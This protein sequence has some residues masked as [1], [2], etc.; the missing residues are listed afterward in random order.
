MGI[1]QRLDDLKGSSGSDYIWCSWFYHRITQE[2]HVRRPQDGGMILQPTW[3]VERRE[4]KIP[5]RRQCV[6]QETISCLLK[7]L[8]IAGKIHLWAMEKGFGYLLTSAFGSSCSWT[9]ADVG[10]GENKL[11]NSYRTDVGLQRA[12]VTHRCSLLPVSGRAMRA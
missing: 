9:W 1:S 3:N 2:K 8:F 11:E 7:Y 5:L 12:G 10:S 6:S 4:V